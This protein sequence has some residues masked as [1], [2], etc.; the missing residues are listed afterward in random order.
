MHH[1]ENV[2]DGVKF[3]TQQLVF[4]KECSFHLFLVQ[5]GEE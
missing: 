2:M 1:T 3:E 5:A 4:A